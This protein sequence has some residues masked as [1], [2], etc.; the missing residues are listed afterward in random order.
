MTPDPAKKLNEIIVCIE[1]EPD[2]WKNTML[3]RIH[4]IATELSKE[5]VILQSKIPTHT[6]NT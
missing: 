1:Q 5:L 2:Y 6:P 4:T 3:L